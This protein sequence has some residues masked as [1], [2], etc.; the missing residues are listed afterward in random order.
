MKWWEGFLTEKQDI[1][2]VSFKIKNTEVLIGPRM[3]TYGT[4]PTFFKSIDGFLVVTET[5]IEYPPESNVR[6]FPWLEG[7]KEF[8][9]EVLFGGLKTLN[10]WIN[11]ISLK[12]VYIHC[13]L[14]SHRAP[15]ILGA[16]LKAYFTDDESNK[17]I[18]N[19]DISH[20]T[21]Y[22]WKF[23]QL[24]NNPIK[25][26]ETKFKL[27]P[28][29]PFL[30]KAIVANTNSDLSTILSRDL[31]KLLPD[32]LVSKNE[33]KERIQ[34]RNRLELITIAK[35]YLKTNGYIRIDDPSSDPALDS[36]L[37]FIKDSIE[38]IVNIVNYPDEKVFQPNISYA[39]ND[40][41]KL[42][43]IYPSIKKMILKYHNKKMIKTKNYNISEKLNMMEIS[44]K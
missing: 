34:K 6:W 29:L 41:K 14:G 44:L 16:F 4:D 43:I 27:I 23:D 3:I 20:A 26:I 24:M 8:P 13:D 5:Y 30:I 39:L 40:N 25:Y 36:E 18:E 1:N 28:T 35:D 9:E 15:S 33:L 2:Y 12:K 22:Y 32:D 10:N 31:I 21:T 42:Y 11:E 17:I 38:Y 37:I 7:A 19:A